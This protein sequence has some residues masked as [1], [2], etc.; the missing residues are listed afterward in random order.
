MELGRRK[1]VELTILFSAASLISAC[2]DDATNPTPSGND[3]GGT[4]P[5]PDAGGGNDAGSDAG[6]DSG[7]GTFACRSSITENHA[8]SV[9]IPIADLSST[10][11]KVYSI[12]GT[13]PHDHEITLE[14]Q[15]LADLKAGISVKKASTFADTHNHDVTILCATI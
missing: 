12:K 2:S 3:A 9:M 10:S 15:D 6:T 1:F 13:S 14:A 11:A 8:H 5:K 4:P 7:G